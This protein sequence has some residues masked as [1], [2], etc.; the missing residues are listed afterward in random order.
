MTAFSPGR[1][2]PRGVELGPESRIA[3]RW[4]RSTPHFSRECQGALIAVQSREGSWQR[5]SMPLSGPELDP[6]PWHAPRLGVLSVRCVTPA[7]RGT[8]LDQP[9]GAGRS[10][11]SGQ[12]RLFG[13]A[14]T[15]VADCAVLLLALAH[16][17][18]DNLYLESLVEHGVAGLVCG[19]DAHYWAP[20]AQI[21]ACTIRALGSHLGC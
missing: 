8:G 5:I 15:L 1:R 20:P 6:G 18:I 21:R 17:H 7:P 19:R 10:P 16:R 13:G 14:W 3:S 9:D 4:P 11:A 12:L 2:S